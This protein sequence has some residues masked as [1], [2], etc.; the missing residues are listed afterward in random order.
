MKQNCQSTQWFIGSCEAT[1]V[2]PQS[3]SSILQN[4][5]LP[6]YTYKNRNCLFL[7]NEIQDQSRKLGYNHVTKRSLY[8]I[9]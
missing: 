4:M 7:Q 9:M 8:N 2:R 6:F 5:P 3:I 1:V